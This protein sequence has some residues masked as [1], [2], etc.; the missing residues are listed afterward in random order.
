MYEH[1]LCFPNFGN[2]KIN[3]LKVECNGVHY[4]LSDSMFVKSAFVGVSE[5]WFLLVDVAEEL[6]ENHDS[7]K[8]D[9]DCPTSNDASLPQDRDNCCAKQN[10]PSQQFGFSNSTKENSEDLHNEAEHMADSNVLK[11]NS[12]QDGPSSVLN[13]ANFGDQI[14][15]IESVKQNHL[16]TADASVGRNRRKRQK[17]NPSQAGSEVSSAKDVHHVHVDSFQAAEVKEKDSDKKANPDSF[18]G[19]C[20]MGGLISEPCPIS[21]MEMQEVSETN[22]VPHTEGDDGMD[23]TNDGNL[24][25]KNEAP[26]PVVASEMKIRVILWKRKLWKSSKKVKKSKK[27]KGAIGGT[28]AV[29]VA[30]N[31]GPPS[32]ISPAE[33]GPTTVN[34]EH[35]SDNV[36]QAGKTDGKEES[37]MK[38]TECSPSVTDV[39]DDDVIQDV[40]ESLK[41]CNNGPANAENADKKSRKKTKK[42]SA[43]VLASPELQAKDDV[44]QQEPTLLVHKVSEVSTSSKSTRKTVNGDSSLVVQSNGTNLGFNRNKVEPQHDGRPIQDDDSVDHSKSIL[45]YNSKE[46][47]RGS[48]TTQSQKKHEIVD[49]GEVIIDKT[50]HK[51][52]VETAVKGK[53]KKNPKPQLP[54][55]E[56]LNGNQH[57]EAKTQANKASS[58][59]SQRSLSKVEPSSS[60]VKPRGNEP[61]SHPDVAKAT[62]TNSR[63]VATSLANKKSLLATA[64][65]IFRHIDNESSDDEDGVGNSNSSTRTLSD[66]SSSSAYSSNSIVKGSSLQNGSYNS[67]Q[68]KLLLAQGHE[69]YNYAHEVYAGRKHKLQLCP[70]TSKRIQ[71]HSTKCH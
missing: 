2:I 14:C 44:D 16:S 63:I 68:T 54:S 48:E 65:A 62:G 13:D 11:K 40:L 57:K 4:H 33:E 27:S 32:E 66:S 43:T 30:H 19:K 64:G 21:P 61:Q 35:L 26:H 41:R 46:V 28:E 59:Q 52:G 31:R 37:K 34:S 55:L 3:S 18:I 67:R 22:R 15:N 38:K 20:S 23:D 25:S 8:Y 9:T 56:M 1:P 36:E 10:S 5:N 49:F 24:E 70:L 60:N 47:P 29:D 12:F 39:K 42:K 50:A 51:A 71:D 58:S 69:W 17:L 6:R 53:R 7:I 45:V